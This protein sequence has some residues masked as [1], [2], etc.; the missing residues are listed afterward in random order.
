MVVGA[1]VH[2]LPFFVVARP[3]LS[4]PLDRGVVERAARSFEAGSSGSSASTGDSMPRQVKGRHMN[5]N[6]R[7][8][9]GMAIRV[10]DF[11]LANPFGYEPA[12]QVAAL[13]GEKVGR[14][15]VLLT[16]QETGELASRTS[17]RHRR[18]LKRQMVQLPLRHLLKIAKSVAAE[19]PEVASGLSRPAFGRSEEA[20]QA[21]VRAIAQ[22]AE[23]HRELFLKHGL[24]EESLEELGQ[25]LKAYEQA[26]HDAN[27]G[28]R[29]HT[30]ARAELQALAKELMR[31]LQQ[32]DG[33]VLYRFRDKPVLMGA[34]TSA[35]NIAWP[36]GEPAKPEAPAEGVKPAA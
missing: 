20:F 3:L 32:L 18:G 21:S 17:T 4:V 35:R 27:A 24:S 1:S 8:K 15:Q 5:I 16:Q 36:L 2:R 14:A 34:W 13:F 28:R 12:D 33:I 10:R 7:L 29:A 23:T 9:V 22:E 31:L 25:M 11:L 30:G 26:V 19:H 6:L